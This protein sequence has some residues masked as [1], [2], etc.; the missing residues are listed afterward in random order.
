MP[1]QPPVTALA[2]HIG[3]VVTA[4][5]QIVTTEGHVVYCSPWGV[6]KLQRYGVPVLTLGSWQDGADDLGAAY[7]AAVA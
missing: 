7:E 1:D 6:V 5:H 3:G 2:A 4:D